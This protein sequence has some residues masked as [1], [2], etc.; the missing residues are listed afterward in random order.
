MEELEA[1]YKEIWADTISRN[2]I[3]QNLILD[4]RPGKT[5]CLSMQGVKKL[6]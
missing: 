3:A 1:P 4:T 5:G 2:V 6:S